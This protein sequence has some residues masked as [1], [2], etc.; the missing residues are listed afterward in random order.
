MFGQVKTVLFWTQLSTMVREYQSNTNHSTKKTLH[1]NSIKF[2]PSDE[3]LSL[4]YKQHKKCNRHLGM[5]SV[6]EKKR[7][8]QKRTIPSI[9]HGFMRYPN[10]K[11]TDYFTSPSGKPSQPRLNKQ[12]Y[13]L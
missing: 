7:V 2:H 5:Q 10:T 1:P 4:L 9:K 3:K 8:V 6:N 11:N 13:G 12:N